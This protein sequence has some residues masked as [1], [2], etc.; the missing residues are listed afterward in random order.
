L[1]SAGDCSQ[2][3]ISA[4]PFQRQ[5][6]GKSAHAAADDGNAWRASFEPSTLPTFDM[7]Q[8][9]V[10]PIPIRQRDKPENDDPQS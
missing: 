4:P 2:T 6:R 7:G 1:F 10:G 3:I 9:Q 8:F 5:R